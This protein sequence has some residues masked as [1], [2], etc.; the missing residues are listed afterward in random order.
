MTSVA[1]D[2]DREMANGEVSLRIR[3]GRHVFKVKVDDTESLPIEATVEPA[4][5]TTHEVQFPKPKPLAPILAREAPS[6]AGPIA[7]G[8]M[9]IAA[10]GTG[11]VTGIVARSTQSSIE[12]SCPNSECAAD[13]D[14]GSM[15]TKAKTFGTPTRAAAGSSRFTAS[16]SCVRTTKPWSRASSTRRRRTRCPPMR[17]STAT[18]RT[19]R[20][21]ASWKIDLTSSDNGIEAALDLAATAQ[22]ALK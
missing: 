5:D 20:T 21:D 4:S 19:T 3:P 18:T 11:V 12:S 16:A 14:L 2:E 10:I 8:A 13:Y 7:L 9:G 6:R 1:E 22:R 17:I 15:R